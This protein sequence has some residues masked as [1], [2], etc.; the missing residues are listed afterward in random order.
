MAIERSPTP[1]KQLLN[2]IESPKAK[3]PAAAAAMKRKGLSVF[4][5]TAL[6]GR[7]SFFMSWLDF[8]HGLP[9]IVLVFRDLKFINRIL[10][11]GIAGFLIYLVFNTMFSAVTLTTRLTAVDATLMKDK[12]NHAQPSV[13]TPFLKEAAHYLGNVRSRDIFKMGFHNE[14]PVESGPPVSSRAVEATKNFRLVGISWSN[15]PDAMI[16][17]TKA[18]RTFFVKRGQMLG[19]VKVEAISKDKVVLSYEGEEV[20]LK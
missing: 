9:G 11:L 15:D 10:E 8:K 4:S 18:L 2:L 14:V 5:V 12:G 7:F 16:E 17:D 3:A 13:I 20:E 1:E 6:K 19:D